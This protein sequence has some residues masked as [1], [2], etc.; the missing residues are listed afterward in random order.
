MSGGREAILSFMRA[1]L[2]MPPD[3]D[4]E[5][6]AGRLADV[7]G[8]VML[9]VKL[10]H[11]GKLAGK[12]AMPTDAARTFADLCEQTLHRHPQSQL[13]NLIM[14]LR[15]GAD[16]IDKAGATPTTEE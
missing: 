5:V 8:D 4:V 16:A 10:S 2:D 11:R 1:Y 15:Y 6:T 13:E 9:V 3:A 7:P 14:A 12:I